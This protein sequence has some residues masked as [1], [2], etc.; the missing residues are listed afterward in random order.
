MAKARL[1]IRNIAISLLLGLVVGYF[2]LPYVQ[3]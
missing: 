2:V 3:F 1:P